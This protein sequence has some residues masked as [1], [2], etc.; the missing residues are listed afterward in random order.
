MPSTT[1]MESKA[2]SISGLVTTV[3]L[4]T[5]VTEIENEIPD[6]NNLATKATLNKKATEITTPESNRLIRNIF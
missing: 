4:N 6:F 5:K 1:E 3:I 2:P